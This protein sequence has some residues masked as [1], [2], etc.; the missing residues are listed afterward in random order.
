MKHDKAWMIAV[1]S[2]IVTT[3]A[4][5]PLSMIMNYTVSERKKHKR[6][7]GYFE[8][9]KEI[10]ALNGITSFFNG[11]L[12]SLLL[13]VNPTINMQF[14]EVLKRFLPGI[15]QKDLALFLAG[16]LSK[17]AAT[18]ATFPMQTLK[19]VMQSGAKDRGAIGEIV[20]ILREFG[21]FG[22]YKGMSS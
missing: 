3:T 11:Y 1:I 6:T 5:T 15:M 10:Y 7:L 14:F 12:F 17:L 22:L 2:G 20:Y 19:T 13:V 8:A 18:L 21:P 16:A 4:T 9:I